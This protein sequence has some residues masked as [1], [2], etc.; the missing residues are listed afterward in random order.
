MLLARVLEA[1]LGPRLTAR[2]TSIVFR[3]ISAQSR[4]AVQQTIEQLAAEGR[5]HLADAVAFSESES[6]A[7]FSKFEPCVPE[8]LLA[9]LLAERTLDLVGA[10]KVMKAFC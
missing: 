6:R 4:V 5:P 3:E 8:R 2:N 10:Q 1:E 7:R 9:K